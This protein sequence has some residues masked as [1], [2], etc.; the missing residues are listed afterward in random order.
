M[1][2]VIKLRQ[3]QKKKKRLDLTRVDLPNLQLDHEIE[4]TS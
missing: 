1:T 3:P 2:R 4:I